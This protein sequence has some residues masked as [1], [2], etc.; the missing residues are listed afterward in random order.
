MTSKSNQQNET[1]AH[2]RFQKICEYCSQLL[3]QR[4]RTCPV[5]L[6]HIQGKCTG[7]LLHEQYRIESTLAHIWNNLGARTTYCRCGERSKVFELLKARCNPEYGKAAIVAK[8]KTGLDIGQEIK[9]FL[10]TSPRVPPIIVS[11]EF[12]IVSYIRL[13]CSISLPSWRSICEVILLRSRAQ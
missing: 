1:L 10:M 9:E 8:G 3:T 7:V 11:N 2:T 4:K 13:S 12:G 6:Y 5:L